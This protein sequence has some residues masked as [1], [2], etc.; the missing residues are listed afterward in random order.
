MYVGITLILCSLL[1]SVLILI[2]CFTKKRVNT[3][4]T[5]IYNALVIAN[6]I[7]LILEL[8]CCYTVYNI[9]K[10]PQITE[11]ICRTFLVSILTWQSLFTLYN[12][13][14]SFKIKKTD[15]LNF[16]KTIG[17]V[18]I[19]T[20]IIM[21]LGVLSLPLKYYNQ[22][23]TVYSYG[24]SANFLYVIVVIYFIS[25]IVMYI[26][27]YN[28]EQ[29][30]KYL[31][32][33]IF[34]FV[35]GIALIIRAIDPG[36]LIISAS[37]AFVTN[38]MYFTIENPDM[39][40]LDEVHKAKEI[41]D[42]ANEEKT[43]FLYNM[44]QEIRNTT[45]EIDIQTD[46]I[47]DSDSLEET[48]DSA[49][50][51]KAI[52]SKFTS[53]TNEILD[54]SKIDSANIKVYNSK[55]NIK[56]IIKQIINVYSDTCKNKEIKFITNID[57]DIPEIL[58]GDYIGL[59]E[60]LTI[61][62]NNSCKYTEKG[63]VELDINTVTKNDICRLIITIEDSG[64]GI[65]SED[66]NKVKLEN[67]S[68]SKANK[69]I[70][71]MNGTMIISSNYGMGTKVKII[72]DQKIC[73]EKDSES[74]KYEEILDDQKILMVDDSESGIKIVEKLL[75]GSNIK[76]D[77]SNNGK[78]CL[79]KIKATKYDL[80]L[81]DEELTQISGGELLQKIKEI[82]NFDTPVILLTKDNNYEYNEEY[83]KLGFIDYVLKPLKKEDLIG[84]INK[85]T[86]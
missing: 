6:F 31:P 78:E 86:K 64:I 27:K 66:I 48:K 39:K 20:F 52:T 69:L 62:L 37:F 10:M 59:K 71:L 84:K 72:L 33:L 77:T 25:W 67:K 75:K 34:I 51:I 63:F 3:Q 55:Y 11:F 24:P 44:T 45:S 70:T 35:M 54:V 56:N 16:K 76:L 58:Y 13:T 14:I 68:L 4:E 61:I 46:E 36:I 29:N 82:R 47:L 73:L 12:Y 21:L 30:R 26:K 1:Y 60:V 57:H 7:N 79:T 2:I 50:N 18:F 83:L 9:D 43:L 74:S 85:H 19:I 38:L 65:N 5:K 8:L 23:D 17:K 81:L 41:S 28:K 53:M 80:I 22:N 40:L 15:K 32:I 49:R 42:N